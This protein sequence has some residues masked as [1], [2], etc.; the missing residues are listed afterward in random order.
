MDSNHLL[1]RQQLVDLLRGGNAHMPFAEAV[2]DFPEA[3][4]NVRPP[5][6]DYT[7]WHLI[8][9]LR[10]VQADILAYLTRADYEAPEWPAE[11]WPPQDAVAT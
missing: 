5:N 1:L 8:E 6:V 3:A 4:I 10:L 11:Y 2:A 7:F 9:H